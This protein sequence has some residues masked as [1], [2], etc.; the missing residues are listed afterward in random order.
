MNAVAVDSAAM[1]GEYAVVID[2]E[3]KKRGLSDYDTFLWWF[4]QTQ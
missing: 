3:R 1:T 2:R 4:K